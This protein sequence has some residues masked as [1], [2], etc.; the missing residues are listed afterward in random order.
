MSRSKIGGII[1]V[2]GQGTR[3]RPLTLH[4]PKALL[5][6]LNRPFLSYQFASFKKAGVG[7]VCLAANPWF[8][9]WQKEITR[10]APAGLKIIWA[11]EK[12]PLGTGGAIRFGFDHLT[13]AVRDLNLFAIFN[14]DVLFEANLKNI[15]RV[16]T[17]NR[18][19]CTV[20]LTRVL[21]SSRFGLVETNAQ[22]RIRSFLEKPKG[23]SRPGWIN[24]GLYVVGRSFL[25]SIPSGEPSSVERDIFPSRLKEGWPLF[26]QKITGYWN[27]IGTPATYLSAHCDLLE[28]GGRWTGIGNLSKGS[29]SSRTARVLRGSR[30]SLSKGSQLEGFVC[31]GPKVRLEPQVQLRDTVVMEGCVIGP[32]VSLTGTILG[33]RCQI[34]EGSIFSQGTV[35]GEGT[36]IPPF[37][38][39]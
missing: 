20:A 23:K 5:P 22:G 1:L 18:S 33:R 17:R 9:R 24:A 19:E 8:K 35:L 26:A 11:F 34:G 37:T 25:E 10:L 3:L 4:Q 6:I 14:G 2:G 30:V 27:D 32:R 38:K 21:D 28:R 36:V 15:F 12:T 29:S 13:Q 7:A 31:L 39:S 16:H